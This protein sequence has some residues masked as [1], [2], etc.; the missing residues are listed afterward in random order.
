V[1]AVATSDA[2][3]AGEYRLAI[4]FAVAQKCSSSFFSR[5]LVAGSSSSGPNSDVQV[6]R[7]LC[8]VAVLQ[9]VPV[10]SLPRGQF[11][12]ARFTRV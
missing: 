8:L 9:L 4:L 6:R 7:V 1:F 12:E 11:P 3:A 5:L 2:F 10:G